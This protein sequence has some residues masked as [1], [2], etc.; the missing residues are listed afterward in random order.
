MIQ[1]DM[2]ALGNQ[3]F[4]TLGDALRT[5]FIENFDYHEDAEQDFEAGLGKIEQ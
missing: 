3:E 1:N 5:K 4:A 2:A